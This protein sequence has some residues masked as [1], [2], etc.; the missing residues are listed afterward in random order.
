MH[1]E[2]GIA[3]ISSDE[4]LD[5]GDLDK[6]LMPPPPD[7]HPSTKLR[8]KREEKARIAAQRNQQSQL[9]FSQLHQLPMTSQFNP[10]NLSHWH[11]S[12][13]YRMLSFNGIQQNGGRSADSY[14]SFTSFNDN[15]NW[16]STPSNFLNQAVGDANTGPTYNL[17]QPMFSQDRE[18]RVMTYNYG[19]S[20]TCN[21]KMYSSS[22]PPQY[23]RL[24]S[25]FRGEETGFY[26]NGS[27]GSQSN[28]SSFPQGNQAHTLPHIDS[29]LRPRSNSF[30][31][32]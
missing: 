29:I 6:L 27:S 2:L 28:A 24:H 3:G 5:W 14:K 9:I 12:D 32:S 17:P 10:S 4:M 7:L 11:N 18:N 1:G 19:A 8:F 20:S 23:E 16:D 25:Y 26:L 15:M 22:V 31:T 21:G 30:Y 13:H